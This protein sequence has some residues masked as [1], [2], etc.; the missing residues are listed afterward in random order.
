MIG[1]AA[2]GETALPARAAVG[3]GGGQRA[4]SPWWNPALHESG[5]APA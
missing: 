4:G 3:V 1:A 5:E 2:A